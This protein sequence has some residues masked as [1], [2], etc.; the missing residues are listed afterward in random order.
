MIS[1][2]LQKA[3]DNLQIQDV[4]VRELYAACM[5]DF[6]PKHE[7][8]IELLTVE[9]LHYV[10]R[11][12][13]V[14]MHG[15]EQLLRV[16]V[17]L[18]ARWVDTEEDKNIEAEEEDDEE[19][20]CC[21]IRAEFIAE[22]Q[23]AESLDQE[24]IEEFCLKNVSYHVW[25]YWRELLSTQCARMHLPRVILPA[26]QFAFNSDEESEASESNGEPSEE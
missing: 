10:D 3:I 24:C 11:S 4:Y 25:P 17:V 19:S 12:S 15:G 7:S 14:E 20:V 8:E 18:G 5:G 22:Y 6:D 21:M 9:R 13:V 26:V 16:H 1:A 2:H 23:M